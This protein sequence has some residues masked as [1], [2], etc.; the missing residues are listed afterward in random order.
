M[1]KF[2]I[3]D[4]PLTLKSGSVQLTKEQF[5]SRTYC[6][7]ALNPKEGLYL[8][9]G[10]ACFKVGETIGYDGPD[11]KRLVNAGL[12][13]MDANTRALE[14]YEAKRQEREER[15]NRKDEHRTSNIEHPT[16]NK[17]QR[18]GNVDVI[19]QTVHDGEGTLLS[20]KEV[21]HSETGGQPVV[22]D[23]E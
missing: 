16:S 11:Y 22:T 13:D 8:V 17:K 2:I 14:E 21:K 7:K 20:E 1:K 10:D 19:N 12:V 15:K 3:T 23:S 6:L 4:K 18:T 5:A 9:T